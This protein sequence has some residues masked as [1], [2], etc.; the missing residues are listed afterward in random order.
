MNFVAYKCTIQLNVPSTGAVPFTPGKGMSRAT[1]ENL[2]PWALAPTASSVSPALG[3]HDTGVIARK[4]C[5]IKWR[6]SINW[7]FNAPQAEF[8][9]SDQT[10]LTPGFDGTRVSVH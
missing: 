9:R 5:C 3:R 6:I 8:A 4:K 2:P 1:E 10:R 7:K